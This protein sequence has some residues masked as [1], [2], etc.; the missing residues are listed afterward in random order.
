VPNPENPL[1]KQI[2]A[3]ALIND[4]TLVTR[5]TGHFATTGVS[6]LN[7][8][9]K[10]ARLVCPRTII[11]PEWVHHLRHHPVTLA[12]DQQVMPRRRLGLK[13]AVVQRRSNAWGRAALPFG[14]QA[15]INRQ[16]PPVD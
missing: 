5:N 2:A 3:T 11:A 14:I 13:L 6:L 1:D 10:I 9:S 16:S 7:P 15:P 4:L 12:A 8:L